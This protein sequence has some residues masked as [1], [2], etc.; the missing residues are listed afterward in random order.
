[1]LE[2]LKST[3]IF[4]EYLHLALVFLLLDGFTLLLLVLDEVIVHLLADHLALLEVLH[5]LEAD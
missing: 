3:L 4:V 1:M 2:A 5:N